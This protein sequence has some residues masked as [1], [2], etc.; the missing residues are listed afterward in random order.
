MLATVP[1]YR[2]SE[3]PLVVG[4]LMASAPPRSRVENAGSGALSLLLHAG[5]LSLAVWLT[6]GGPVRV[7]RE[8]STPDV[9]TPVIPLP[10][11]EPPAPPTLGKPDGGGASEL[12]G[13]RMLTQPANIP[14]EIPQIR[15]GALVN[16]GDYTAV[17]AEGGSSS[18]TRTAPAP[19]S[20]DP[21]DHPGS[22]TVITVAPELQ[23][24]S[25]VERA[26]ARAYPPTLRDVGITGRVL[27]WVYVGEEGQVLKAVVKTTSGVGALDEA[28]LGVARV[29]RFS[30]GLNRDQKVKV[31]V[32]IPVD[33]RVNS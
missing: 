13:F 1:W 28:A 3:Q 11:P 2:T 5:L 31:W 20:A 22:F 25:E 6:T 15:P 9:F 30:P 26:L 4:H 8:A 16:E 14:I 7:I 23:N 12:R 33:F 27:V 17:G 21:M 18:G 10:M 19:V 24:R 29:M 32:A